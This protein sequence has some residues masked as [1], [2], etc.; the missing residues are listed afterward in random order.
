M[1]SNVT[2]CLILCLVIGSGGCTFYSAEESAIDACSLVTQ[3]E[4]ERTLGVAAEQIRAS[5][6]A[7]EKPAAYKQAKCAYRLE[8]HEGLSYRSASM[9]VEIDSAARF[10]EYKLHFIKLD[11]PTYATAPKTVKTKTIAVSSIGQ[12]AVW[13]P[14]E[15][16]M[17]DNSYMAF[18]KNDYAVKIEIPFVKR[19]IAEI[20]AAKQLAGAA[21]TRIP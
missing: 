3:T 12:G 14:V 13:V 17:F 21:S 7:A 4:I 19:G 16:D 9:F 18:V 15:G 2:G 20:E 1:F 6:F 11:D 5:S 10:E 8:L